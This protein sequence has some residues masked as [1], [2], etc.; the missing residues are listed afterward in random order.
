VTDAAVVGRIL[1]EY[2]QG[3]AEPSQ[4]RWLAGSVRGASVTYQLVW[5]GK[6]G[7]VAR[8]FRT[9]LP[10]AWQYQG[11]GTAAVTDWLLGRAATLGWLE[12]HG[13]PAPR[14]ARTRSGDPVGLAGVWVTLATSYVDGAVVRPDRNGLR[15]LGEALGRLHSLDASSFAAGGLVTDLGAAVSVRAGPGASGARAAGAGAAGAGA[16]VLAAWHPRTAIPAAVGRL[17][18]VAGLLP[19]DLLPM[20]ERF[21]AVLAAVQRQAGELPM[22]VVHGAA[23]PANTVATAAGQAVLVG[24]GKAGLGLPLLDLGH[25]L[26]ECQADNGPVVGR[27]E[28]W[29]LRLAEDR[30]A[31]VVTGY[32]RWRQPT[33]AELDLLLEGM[34]FA[35][36]F[37][38]AAHV[39]QALIG[40]V[41]GTT[42]DMRLARL[43][44][45]LAVS[46]A[47]AE[48]ARS[49]FAQYAE[50]GRLGGADAGA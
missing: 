12:E 25:C 11:C 40:G 27:P 33:A 34:Q 29:Q 49:H 24:W 30:L 39:E 15:L 45:R 6:P 3:G 38:G 44:N 50:R 23:W 4:V 43:R 18:A 16:A 47:V 21:R 37:A 46:P 22:A 28:P 17:D 1:R 41:R 7:L 5:P 48:V 32:C 35:A 14:V 26:L 19:D 2:R 31:A 9:D 8:A 10:V 20:V 42:M 36:A 13:Y